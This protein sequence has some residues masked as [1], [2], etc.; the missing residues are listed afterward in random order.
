MFLRIKDVRR[1]DIMREIKDVLEKM[2]ITKRKRKY[3]CN[4]F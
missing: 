4:S 2:K 3:N 1:E